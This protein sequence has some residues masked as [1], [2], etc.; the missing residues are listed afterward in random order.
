MNRNE[1]P[2]GPTAASQSAETSGST[3]PSD[4]AAPGAD[5]S[6]SFW[7]EAQGT[8]REYWEGYKDLAAQYATTYF[9]AAKT[10]ARQFV[11]DRFGVKAEAGEL[12]NKA[13][14]TVGDKVV[15][16]LRGKYN[17]DLENGKVTTEDAHYINNVR[18]ALDKRPG[19]GFFGKL[20]N[21][22]Y[23]WVAVNFAS[24]SAFAMATVY[25]NSKFASETSS[26][27]Q[28][29]DGY[30]NNSYLLFR[31]LFLSMFTSPAKQAPQAV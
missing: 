19:V 15:A 20:F 13:V 25:C 31:E 27:G 28:N 9:E 12:A 26:S 4:G 21:R 5:T 29:R 6:G 22:A 2:T 24:A 3:R 23:A 11:E 10:S 8:V 16:D 18:E 1:N 14:A 7:S 17:G 30:L